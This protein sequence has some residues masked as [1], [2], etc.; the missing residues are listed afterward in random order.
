MSHWRASTSNS[1]DNIITMKRNE[2][3]RKIGVP[4]K[5]QIYLVD[6]VSYMYTFFSRS[7]F[8]AMYVM[9]AVDTH[10]SYLI[11]PYL[12]RQSQAEKSVEEKLESKENTSVMSLTHS[13]QIRYWIRLRISNTNANLRLSLLLAYSM[14]SRCSTTQAPPI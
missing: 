11:Y 10:T 13:I 5:Y 2:K 9:C 3:K 4:E 12:F 14:G 1:T 6:Y 8:K 7:S